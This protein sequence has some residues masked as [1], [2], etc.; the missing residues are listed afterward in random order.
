MQRRIQAWV[1]EDP[2]LVALHSRPLRYPPERGREKGIDVELALDLLRLALD[3]EYDVGILAS[4]DSDLVPALELVSRRAPGKILETVSLQPLPQ[5]RA[6]EPI[7]IPGGG[8]VRRRVSRED[9][10]Q[11]IDRRNFLRGPG[12]LSPRGGRRP[13]RGPR[14]A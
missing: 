3:D 6:A 7:D 8:V 4:A 1:A 5:C 14:R 2:A 10:E 9:F 11:I 13:P 12:P